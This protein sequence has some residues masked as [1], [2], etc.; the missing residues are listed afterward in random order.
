[1]ET[2]AEMYLVDAIPVAGKDI[3]DMTGKV[4]FSTASLE[5]IK[6]LFS[7]YTTQELEPHPGLSKWLVSATAPD[8]FNL[9]ARP[10]NVV[11]TE[12]AG[13]IALTWD[14]STDAKVTGYN[15]YR[16]TS[17]GGTY[18]LV[19][20]AITTGTFTD[21]TI[22]SGTTYFY[23]VTAITANDESFAS[24]VVN[25]A[26]NWVSVPA[27]IQAEDYTNMSGVQTEN[28]LNDGGGKN[29]G[30]FDPDDFIEFKVNVATTR[31]YIFVY[32]LA[33]NVSNS[34]GFKVL[35]DGVEVDSRAVENTNGW[36]VWKDIPSPTIELTAGNH[37]IR[38]VSI[39]K[40]WNIDWF[41]VSDL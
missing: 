21:T 32:R 12:N 14:A 4:D 1:M 30:F 19:G 10:T 11:L 5:E 18:T 6:A 28:F 38:L 27:T 31:N 16:N 36:T 37:T 39:G 35:V 15:V 29:V 13:S 23:K 9:P 20:D 34:N 2:W 25:T 22:V 17:F 26:L 8:I 3:L 7:S 40:E 33:S 24:D 41:K